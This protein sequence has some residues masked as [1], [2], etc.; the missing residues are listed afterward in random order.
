MAEA[1]WA[2]SMAP[3]N[4]R[5]HDERIAALKFTAKWRNAEP[6]GLNYRGSSGCAQL[7]GEILQR[8]DKCA[9]LCKKQNLEG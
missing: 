7:S 4:Q 2:N 6:G 5:L 3:E 1:K 8:G 9:A